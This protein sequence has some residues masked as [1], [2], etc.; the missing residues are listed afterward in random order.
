MPSRVPIPVILDVDT[1]IDD[2][3][4]LLLAARHPSIDLLGVTCVAGNAPIEH[5]VRNTLT[6]LETAGRSDVPVIAGATRPLLAEPDHA[7]HVMGADGFGEIEWPRSTRSPHPGHAVEWLRATL[8]AAPEPVTLV[9]LA[10]MANIA[11]LMRLHPHVSARIARIVVMGGSAGAGNA[12]PLAE[13]NVFHDPEAAAIVFGTEVPI[14]MYGLDVFDQVLLPLDR[15]RELESSSS[16]VARLAGRLGVAFARTIGDPI[17]LGDAGAVAILIDPD[18]LGTQSLRVS[19]V[20]GDGLARGA[21]QVDRRPL[22]SVGNVPLTGRLVDVGLH[23]DADRLAHVWW[24]SVS[25]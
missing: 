13:F 22:T 23:V 1:G 10:P 18:A 19:V 8:E 9:T 16:P 24:E 12:T 11:L 2:A 21:T 5:V 15:F 17:C 7:L 4:A 25:A 20:T 14:T 3:F 6:V